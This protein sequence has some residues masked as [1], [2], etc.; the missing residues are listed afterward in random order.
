MKCYYGFMAQQ[1]ESQ[2]TYFVI[3]K[4]LGKYINIH[5]KFDI[6]F[7]KKRKK[8][9]KIMQILPNNFPL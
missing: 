9:T 2:D 5:E 1:I 4:W 6:S 8:K 7:W 3:A